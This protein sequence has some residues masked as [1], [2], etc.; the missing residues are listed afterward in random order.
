[1]ITPEQANEM[2]RIAIEKSKKEEAD[3]LKRKELFQSQEIKRWLS[4]SHQYI[5]SIFKDIEAQS[6]NGKYST[7]FYIG[8]NEFGDNVS[9]TVVKDLRASGWN[10]RRVIDY[11]SI[12]Y[13]IDKGRIG[14]QEF[15]VEVKW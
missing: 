4:S 6:R 7:R 13:S 12:Y 9:N 2:T 1:M 10:A 3:A 8:K 14:S 11:C 5:R 15:Y